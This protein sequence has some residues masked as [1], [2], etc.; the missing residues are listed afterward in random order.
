MSL[1]ILTSALT[2]TNGVAWGSVHAISGK[3]NI[4]VIA[5]ATIFRNMARLALTQLQLADIWKRTL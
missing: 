1:H 3:I 2:G 4:K 5:S